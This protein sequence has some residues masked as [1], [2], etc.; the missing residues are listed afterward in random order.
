M[1]S[2][3]P[4]LEQNIQEIYRKALDAD[5]H[6]AQLKQQGMAKFTAIFDQN[7]L[8]KCTDRTF[9]PYV[10]ELTQDI[11]DFRD[12]AD[13]AQLNIILKKM[14]LLYQLLGTMKNITQ[15]N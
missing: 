10:A 2:I 9:M 13:Q 3:L 5:A 14:E 7:S 11:A 4:H 1:N 12:K 8:F 15:S 6:L